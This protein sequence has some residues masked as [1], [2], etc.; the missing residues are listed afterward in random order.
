VVFVSNPIQFI[1]FRHIGMWSRL[2]ILPKKLDNIK[3]YLHKSRRYTHPKHTH[4]GH[5]KHT[6][7]PNEQK[8]TVCGILPAAQYVWQH[9]F[10]QIHSHAVEIIITSVVLV[11]YLMYLAMDCDIIITDMSS[12]QV[13]SAKQDIQ[14]HK[15][16]MLY[17]ICKAQ[18][19]HANFA[20]SSVRPSVCLFLFFCV[21]GVWFYNKK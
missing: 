18:L 19:Y 3:N 14:A 10:C 8:H 15:V 20:K 2:Y 12:L 7:S 17:V 9:H 4:S 11:K 6:L 21:R 1:C 16:Y 13:L 5:L